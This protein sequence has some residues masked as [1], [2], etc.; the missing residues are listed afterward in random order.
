VSKTGQDRRKKLISGSQCTNAD[1][2]AFGIIGMPFSSVEWK[3]CNNT[4][5]LGFVNLQLNEFLQTVAEAKESMATASSSG[6]GSR[7]KVI[8][9]DSSFQTNKL[10]SISTIKN[11]SN[12]SQ[13]AVK[14][15]QH[16]MSSSP[17]FTTS[18]NKSTPAKVEVAL[19][20]VAHTGKY[21]RKAS[22]VT[23]PYNS[24]PRE[25]ERRFVHPASQKLL[26]ALIQFKFPDLCETSVFVQTER[27]YGPV[28]N[29][30]SVIKEGVMD[31]AVVFQPIGPHDQGLCLGPWEDKSFVENICNGTGI[32]QLCA[33]VVA[34][35][36]KFNRVLRYPKEMCGILTNGE[37]FI[38]FRRR[39]GAILGER[40]N[41]YFLCQ[42]RNEIVIGLVHFLAVCAENLAILMNREFDVIDGI[43]R[44]STQIRDSGGGGNEEEEEEEEEAEG[45][46][47]KE[48]G[49]DQEESQTH[50]APNSQL[51]IDE[52]KIRSSQYIAN[53]KYSPM[54][55]Y[56]QD[57]FDHVPVPR[58]TAENLA[59]VSTMS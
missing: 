19:P 29:S 28:E 44:L 4:P 42:S 36:R 30:V 2:N 52:T 5:M 21:P 55:T 1:F 33:E 59:L 24:G 51:N 54:N 58:L 53:T 31:R 39:P 48:A 38:I 10:Q 7:T 11:R 13:T 25:Y 46:H 14:L 47:L 35:E 57:Y 40:E 32:S 16:H 49:R 43:R 12:L 56:L 26:T 9:R 18:S 45:C 34:E 6:S 3:D 15:S 22:A 41:H 8:S 23:G 17:L 27:K 50:G 37:Q 20:Q